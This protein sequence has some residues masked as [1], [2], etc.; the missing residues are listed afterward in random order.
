MTTKCNPIKYVYLFWDSEGK[1]HLSE[2]TTDTIKLRKM[3]GKLAERHGDPD[4]A[5]FYRN[6]INSVIEGIRDRI[7]YDKAVNREAAK[8]RESVNTAHSTDALGVP[9]NSKGH[10]VKRGSSYAYKKEWL[11]RKKAKLA[12]AQSDIEP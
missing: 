9:L 7:K 8:F 1:S 12:A 3:A 4:K 2:P 6:N 5:L 10:H 11:A